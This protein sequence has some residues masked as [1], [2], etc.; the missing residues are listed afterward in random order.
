MQRHPFTAPK[1]G[2]FRRV[3][4]VV[5]TSCWARDWT[6]AFRRAKVGT[7]PPKWPLQSGVKECDA[8]VEEG[9][10]GPPSLGQTT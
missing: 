9:L 2:L 3:C 10:D 8:G 4:K 6:R 7:G 1:G 5:G